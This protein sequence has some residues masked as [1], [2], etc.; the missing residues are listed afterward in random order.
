MSEGLRNRMKV[1][2]APLPRNFEKKTYRETTNAR[3]PYESWTRQ[4]HHHHH[5]QQQQQQQPQHYSTRPPYAVFTSSQWLRSKHCKTWTAAASDT[6]WRSPR[7]SRSDISR[8]HPRERTRPSSHRQR[9]RYLLI[10]ALAFLRVRACVR[11]FYSSAFLVCSHVP[12]R[13]IIDQR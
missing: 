11:A 8:R 1:K 13:S 12:I 7:G 3:I 2:F 6:N 9:R 10:Q 4:H 5:H